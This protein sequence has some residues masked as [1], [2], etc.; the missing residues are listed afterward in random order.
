[1]AIVVFA[2][3]AVKEVTSTAMVV[4]ENLK[5]YSR[6]KIKVVD[7]LLVQNS[8]FK[9]EMVLAMHRTFLYL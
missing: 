2:K 3:V 8:V 9:Q 7:F 1:M 4:K 6:P 5:P